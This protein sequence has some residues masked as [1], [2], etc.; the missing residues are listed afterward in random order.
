MIRKNSVIMT[1]VFTVA[2]LGV[3]DVALSHDLATGGTQYHW[4]A[5]R[6][7]HMPTDPMATA[8][9]Q[10]TKFSVPFYVVVLPNRWAIGQVLKIC[11]YGGSDQIRERILGVAQQWLRYAN[12]HF[13]AGGAAGRT[14]TH[15]DGSQ[16]R[17]GFSEPG[18]W[19]Y[20]GTDSIS[21]DLV[22][23]DLASMNFQGFDAD[24]PA[25]PVFT[26]VVLHEF[27]HAL[28]FHHEHQSPGE[29]CD[30]QYNWPKLYAFYKTA[31]GW[32]QQ[33]VDAN[34]R[35]LMAD[36][37]AYD[38][39]QPDPKS[40]MVYA[41]DPQFL[42]R[43]TASPCYF[44]ENDSI[45]AMDEIGAERTYP[46]SDVMQTLLRDKQDLQYLIPRVNASMA[47]ILK[48]QLKLTEKQLAP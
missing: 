27:G 44:K 43:G 33:K 35:Q 11:F 36:R 42:I 21:S 45:S 29:G 15:L 22:N 7:G 30:K 12:L 34:V 20:I 2:C 18:Y 4:N 23:K 3:C 46:K 41:S 1:V 38:W 39:S 10:A 40:V 24:P 48:T 6:I 28:G 5:A 13:D 26:G 16:I 17:I 14:C 37:T 47:P 19:S 9:L 8:S 31:Y 25:D 32:D